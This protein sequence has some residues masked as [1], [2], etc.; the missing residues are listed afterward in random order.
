MLSR[1]FQEQINNILS[2]LNPSPQFVM[3]TAVLS[4][5]VEMITST[6]MRNYLVISDEIR[7]NVHITK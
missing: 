5:E 1:G 2:L 6:L 7:R 4:P 3:S